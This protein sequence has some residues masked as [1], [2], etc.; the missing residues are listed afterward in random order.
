M[1]IWFFLY[2]CCPSKTKD[3]RLWTSKCSEKKLIFPQ[4]F[5]NP[6]NIK[7]NLGFSFLKYLWKY[8]KS[9]TLY[10]R[11]KFRSFW[12][13]PPFWFFTSFYLYIEFSGHFEFFSKKTY[14]FWKILTKFTPFLINPPFCF[15]L[16]K[17]LFYEK[18]FGP[19]RYLLIYF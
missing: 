7:K 12:I 8:I 5:F 4:N 10:S 3:L 17:K 14:R 1:K 16:R 11:T 19:W 6:N 13:N 2:G 9:K 18:V 15:F